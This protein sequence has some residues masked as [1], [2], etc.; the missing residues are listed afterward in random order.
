MGQEGS[1]GAKSAKSPAQGPSTPV[2]A[3][4]PHQ[5]SGDAYV[6]SQT[7]GSSDQSQHAD[8]PTSASVVSNSD[9]ETSASKKSLMSRMTS[10]KSP[11]ASS[12]TSM[13]AKTAEDENDD[14]VIVSHGG[15]G[16]DAVLIDPAILTLNSLPRFES[17]LKEKSSDWKEKLKFW[18]S[19]SVSSEGG[20]HELRLDVRSADS[21]TVT[22]H[23]YFR[24]TS[25]TIAA[26]Q[27]LVSRKVRMMEGLLKDSADRTVDR[28]REARR[29]VEPAKLF[30]DIST[31]VQ[32]ALGRLEKLRS[33]IEHLSA[34]LPEDAR[35]GL[36]PVPA[37]TLGY[38]IV[39]TP[40]SSA[41]ALSPISSRVLETSVDDFLDGSAASNTDS[42]ATMP[43][44][45]AEVEALLAQNEQNRRDFEDAENDDAHELGIV[46][47]LAS[48]DVSY[49]H[50]ESPVV[51]E[52]ALLVSSGVAESV[53]SSDLKDTFEEDSPK[54]EAGVLQDATVEPQNV[55]P[56]AESLPEVRPV[57]GETE[58]APIS[59][60][61]HPSEDR[62]DEH[63]LEAET[64]DAEPTML[65]VQEDARGDD[66][67]SDVMT[68]GSVDQPSVD[69]LSIG[70]TE[71]KHHQDVATD[72]AAEMAVEEA[73][74][75]EAE[76]SAE[77]SGIGNTSSKKTKK[78]KK[79]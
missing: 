12:T 66:V 1:K 69:V 75:G 70:E 52:G 4:S 19:K 63:R 59:D 73:E 41:G 40:T 26:N 64:S 20:I 57:D 60:A 65:A 32:S 34:L 30:F 36:G 46:P 21:I 14:I 37:I 5:P 79:R 33:Q 28:A 29:A 35:D 42:S 43:S 72:N 39:G 24:S 31:Q 62:S 76:T 48:P 55:E 3:A 71:S 67:V 38:M 45:T 53:Q 9:K 25:R 13:T 51:Q 16:D 78:N 49:T 8:S 61:E 47:A 2:A 27:D 58:V 50:V 23:E 74:V 15:S 11:S 77:D 54:I 17:L 44:N 56:H 18:G 7:Q 6:S 68:T 22:L 10:R